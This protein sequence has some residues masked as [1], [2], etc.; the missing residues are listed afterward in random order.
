[1][2]DFFQDLLEPLQEHVGMRWLEDQCRTEPNSLVSTP[3]NVE[4]C[5]VASIMLLVVYNG[6]NTFVPASCYNGI[7]GG[8]IRTVDSTEC[9][10]TSSIHDHLWISILHTA[11]D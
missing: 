5:T 10:N 7:S 9:A 2:V 6:W 3:S 1:M 4:T 11:Q 8:C